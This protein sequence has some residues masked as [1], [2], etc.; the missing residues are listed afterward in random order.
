MSSSGDKKAMSLKIATWNIGGGITGESHQANGSPNLAYYGEILGKY[1]PHLVCLQES[2]HYD[3]DTNQTAELAKSLGYQYAYSTPISVSHLE[4]DANLALGLISKYPIVSSRYTEFENPGLTAI[5]PRGE[6]WN[7][8]DKG[9]C[10]YII[11]A[12]WGVFSVLNAHCFP[13]HYFSANATEERFR[14]VWKAL[15]YGLESARTNTPCLAAIDLNFDDISILLETE[16]TP[17]R[18]TN[19]INNMP[20]TPKGIQ[21]DYLLY[22]PEFCLLTV[23]IIPTKSDHHLCIVEFG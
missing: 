7:L 3:N 14:H 18:F 1:Q 22:T 4:S 10:T 20:T 5:G 9:Y 13:L 12:G 17:H 6:E 16:L 15:T 2:H 11:D 23:S 21:Q 19:A 8:F